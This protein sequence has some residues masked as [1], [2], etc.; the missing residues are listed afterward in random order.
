MFKDEL[1]H[2]M[3]DKLKQMA[4]K[5]IDDQQKET[6]EFKAWMDKNK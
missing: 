5:G 1:S 6:S 2:V 3:N 4:K